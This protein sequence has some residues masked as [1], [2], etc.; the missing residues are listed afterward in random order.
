MKPFLLELTQYTKIHQV[1]YIRQFESK[2][3]IRIYALLKD[4]RLLSYRDIEIEALKKCL[5]Y[6]KAIK[7][8]QILADLY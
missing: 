8:L 2:Y 7:I 3:A 6:Q 5:F 1:E 4:Y